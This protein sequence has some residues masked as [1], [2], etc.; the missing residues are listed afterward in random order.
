VKLA[1]ERSPTP[2]GRLMVV[3]HDLSSAVPA[4]GIASTLQ[5]AIEDWDEVAPSLQAQRFRLTAN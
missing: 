5:Q 3:S 1:T 4:T 2:D